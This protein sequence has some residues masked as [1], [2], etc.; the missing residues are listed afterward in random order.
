MYLHAPHFTNIF[1]LSLRAQS[2]ARAGCVTATMKG[3]R[4]GGQ[5]CELPNA[6]EGECVRCGGH[7]GNCE[8]CNLVMIIL[9]VDS[10][11]ILT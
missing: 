3:S 4:S 2:R 11:L 1:V 5:C 9:A 8:F 7:C 6:R 10:G